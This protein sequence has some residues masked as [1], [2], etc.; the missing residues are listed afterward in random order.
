MGGF[1]GL[2]DAESADLVELLDHRCFQHAPSDDNRQGNHGRGESLA[3]CQLGD[4]Q[5]HDQ[6]KEAG[7]QDF[8]VGQGRFV[9]LAEFR[10]DAHKGGIDAVD[11]QQDTCPQGDRGHLRPHA[12]HGRVVVMDQIVDGVSQYRESHPGGAVDEV[13]QTSFFC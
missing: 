8:P 10:P 13:F 2:A 9:I 11:S 4:G 1:A 7:G 3:Q 5:C 6:G 12:G